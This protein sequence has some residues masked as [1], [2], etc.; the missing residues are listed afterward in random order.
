MKPL[1][2]LITTSMIWAA[3]SVLAA[4]TV[5]ECEMRSKGFG[6]FV[7]EK[8]YFSLEQSNSTGMVL[9]GF[10]KATYDEAIVAEVSKRSG[11]TW[12]YK[13]EVEHFKLGNGGTATVKMRARLNTKSGKLSVNG[14]LTGYDNNISGSGQC[15]VLS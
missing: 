14:L 7:G 2:I 11:T 4:E 5:F 12:Q 3:P 6:G 1:A 15:K 9:D 8:M 10:I 13:W